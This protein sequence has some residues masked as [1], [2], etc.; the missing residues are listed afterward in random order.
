MKN[1]VLWDVMPCH[2]CKNLRFGGTQRLLMKEVL[3]S[4][5][6]SVLTRATRRTSQKTPFFKSSL[7]SLSN[8]GS[9][10]LE[11]SEPPS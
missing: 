10:S 11:A 5:E 4:S 6:T 2:A 9:W 3:S 8:N 7:S 1:G